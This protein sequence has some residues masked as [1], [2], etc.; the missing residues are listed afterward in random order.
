[1]NEPWKDDDELFALARNELY[2]AVVGDIMDQMGLLHQFLPPQ[3]QPLREDMIVIGRVMPVLEADV[4]PMQETSGRNPVLNRPFG[5]MLEALDDLRKNEVYVCSGASPS[6]ALWGELM[7]ACALK[8]GAAGAV[9]NGYSRDTRGI[10]KLNFPCFS[11]GRYSQ[12]QAPRGKVLDF[13]VPIQIGEVDVRSGDVVFGDQDGVCIVPSTAAPE[14][15]SKA[16]EKARGERTVLKA[17]QNGM[18]AREAFDTYG[19]M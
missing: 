15:F 10:L 17:V 1:M 12:D 5:L 14:V 2:T 18:S 13:R 3:V 19:I 16:V 11:C 7:S 8:R 9:V 4:L 6:Y